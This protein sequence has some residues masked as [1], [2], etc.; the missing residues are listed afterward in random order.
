LFLG[1]IRSRAD[2]LKLVVEFSQIRGFDGYLTRESFDALM[3]FSWERAKALE[4]VH[5]IASF[6]A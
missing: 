1:L 2:F 6:F 5:E 4:K 3:V